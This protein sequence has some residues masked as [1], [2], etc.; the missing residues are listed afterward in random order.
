MKDIFHM[1][2]EMI[3]KKKSPIYNKIWTNQD[4]L[5]GKNTEKKSAMTIGENSIF[6]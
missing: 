3:M 6:F 5:K 1:A 2:I 4:Q